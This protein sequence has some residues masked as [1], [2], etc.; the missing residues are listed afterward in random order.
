VPP[1]CPETAIFLGADPPG[2]PTR[3]R[4]YKKTALLYLILAFFCTGWSAAGPTYAQDKPVTVY[5]FWTTGCPHCI[6]E[7]EFLAALEH[8]DRDIKVG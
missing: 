2:T 5:L 3:V 8:R 6:H 4:L 1:S 7:K